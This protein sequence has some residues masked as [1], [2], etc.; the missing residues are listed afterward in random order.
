MIHLRASPEVDDVLHERQGSLHPHLDVVKPP[1][2]AAHA[3]RHPVSVLDLSLKNNNT[4]ERKARG[5]PGREAVCCRRT[6]QALGMRKKVV[7][8]CPAAVRPMEECYYEYI[9][10]FSENS[11][12]THSHAAVAVR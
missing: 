4:H 3:L 11:S 9:L 7:A 5:Q 1:H 10:A 8:V 2:G 6:G 12:A